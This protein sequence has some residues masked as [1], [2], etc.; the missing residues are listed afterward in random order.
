MP[1]K[2]NPFTHKLDITDVANAGATSI[3]SITPNSGTNPVVPDING[4]IAIQGSGS[5]T[6]VGGTN[7]LTPQ[8]TGLTN[9]TVL[10]GAGTDTITKVGPG[11][12]G[13]VLMSNGAGVDPSFQNGGSSILN[14][15]T[16]DSGGA[17]S[18]TLGN[19]N[20]LGA[21]SIT[22]VGAGSTLTTQ[23]TGLTLNAIQVGAGTTTLT[24]LGPVNRAV[25]TSSATGVPAM[26][27]LATNG[28][29][30]IGSTAG[31]PAAGT[32]TGTAISV[33]NGS[34]SISLSVT[35]GGLTWNNV[36]G[37]SQ[38]VFSSNGYIANRATLVT[39]TM[40]STNSGDV[41]RIVG[42][43]A[44]GW[45]LL[46]SGTQRFFIG[47]QASTV[48]TGSLSSTNAGDCVELVA[49]NSTD[50][51]VTSMIGNITVV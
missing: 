13:Q 14:T 24:Q 5:I 22:T 4:L 50:I 36:T 9:H 11:T 25:L 26:T 27:A 33:T 48:T 38:T 47:S 8:L 29:I 19:F 44:G 20:L 1:F 16:G 21:G 28:Q 32:I 15:I 10:V 3:D 43:G 40:N 35:G 2:F 42:K 18:P 12:L 31:A 17:L 37:A 6:T 49:L 30:I 34:N 7:S 46:P 45:T 41:S 39:F 23:L 51:I